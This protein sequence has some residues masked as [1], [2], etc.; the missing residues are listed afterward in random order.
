MFRVR[1]DVD[2]FLSEE[3]EMPPRDPMVGSLFGYKSPRDVRAHP[4]D[5]LRLASACLVVPVGVVVGVALMGGP[6][7]AVSAIMSGFMMG[8]LFLAI[9]VYRSPPRRVITIRETES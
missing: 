3:G 4:M 9:T 5:L 7:G 8:V 6:L 2:G 1:K